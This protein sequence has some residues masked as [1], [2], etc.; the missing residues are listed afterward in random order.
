MELLSV[1][2]LKH[3]SAYC[4]ILNIFQKQDEIDYAKERQEFLVRIATE[5]SDETGVD[6]ES[7]NKLLLGD[8]SVRTYE[9]KVSAY[10]SFRF[11]KVHIVFP[12]QCF[13]RCVFKREGFINSQDEPQN[14]YI[15]DSLEDTAKV[16]RKKLIKIIKKC[17]EVKKSDPCESAFNVSAAQTHAGLLWIDK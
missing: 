16:N 4:L 6:F 3:L 14:D 15:V 10:Y 13:V 9:A 7:A 5:C 1:Y 12:F 2:T 8:L 17:T 11:E